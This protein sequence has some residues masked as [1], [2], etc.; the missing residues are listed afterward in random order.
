MLDIDVEPLR[1][2]LGRT[3][4]DQD[5]AT[6]APLRDM[7]ATFDRDE[8][9]LASANRFR[10]AGILC[11]SPTLR[12]DANSPKTACRPD[13]ACCQKCL[14]LAACMPARR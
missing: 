11:I 9:R 6:E 7:A 8:P 4:V 5:V 2:Q 3:L 14:C 13:A 10:L 12:S 1:A